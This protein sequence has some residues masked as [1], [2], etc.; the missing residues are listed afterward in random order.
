[1]KDE[2]ADL[3]ADSHILND[4]REIVI[5]TAEPLVPDPNTFEVQIAIAN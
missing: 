2:T 5:H 3:L 1:V 4:V